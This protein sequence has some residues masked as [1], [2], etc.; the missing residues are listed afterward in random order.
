[1][2]SENYQKVKDHAFRL[3]SF[4]PRS[5]KELTDK[6]TV[7]CKKKKYP[8]DF[9]Q[10]IADELVEKKY[11]D[12]IAFAKWWKEQRELHNPK[13]DRVIAYEL[14]QKGVKKEDVEALF[15]KGRE[16]SKENEFQKAQT[17]AAK[18]MKILRAYDPKTRLKKLQSALMSRGFDWDTISRVIDSLSER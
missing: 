5:A 1:M 17:I 14:M 8:L 12:D 18:K 3:L 4:R 6:L 16:H 2:E 11:L 15:S 10:K 9:P 7:Y 13:S